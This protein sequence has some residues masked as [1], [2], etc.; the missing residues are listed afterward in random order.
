MSLFKAYSLGYVLLIASMV[1]IGVVIKFMQVAPDIHGFV[2]TTI[3]IAL[4][5]GGIFYFRAEAG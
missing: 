5:N 3:G 1:G 2:D 4:I